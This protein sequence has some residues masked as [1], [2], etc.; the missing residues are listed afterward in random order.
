MRHGPWK[1]VNI[2]L[3]TPFEWLQE[4]YSGLHTASSHIRASSV[5]SSAQLEGTGHAHDAHTVHGTARTQAHEHA[6]H[7]KMRHMGQPVPCG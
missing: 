1:G 4:S 7:T 2:F 5:R 6:H 3:E